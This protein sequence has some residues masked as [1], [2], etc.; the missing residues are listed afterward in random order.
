MR[1]TGKGEKSRM[2]FRSFPRTSG[3]SGAIHR[4]KDQPQDRSLLQYL[5]MRSD[6]LDLVVYKNS[7]SV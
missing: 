7:V 1:R 2:I 6:P 4:V 5:G 3:Q